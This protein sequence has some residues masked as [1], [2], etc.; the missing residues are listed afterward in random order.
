MPQV[1]PVQGYQMNPYQLHPMQFVRGMTTA[2]VTSKGK[3]LYHI[4]DMTRNS[5]QVCNVCC[6]NYVTVTEEYL[7]KNHPEM[8]AMVH[9]FGYAAG[10]SMPRCWSCQTAHTRQSKNAPIQVDMETFQN[11]SL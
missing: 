7:V 11:T 2:G 10:I 1:A 5:M 8:I 4:M 9:S 3:R 6:R